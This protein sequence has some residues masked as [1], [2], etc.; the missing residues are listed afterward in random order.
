MMSQS[1]LLVAAEST[2]L[3]VSFPN[4]TS[5]AGAIAGVAAGFADRVSVEE[6]SGED[7]I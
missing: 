1:N 7:E 4:S 5:P 6:L 2:N 3:L